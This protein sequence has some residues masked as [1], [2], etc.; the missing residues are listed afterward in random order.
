MIAPGE[1]RYRK[2]IAAKRRAAALC[3]DCGKDSG[4]KYRCAHCEGIHAAA[5]VRA[6]AKA[7]G[8]VEAM[9]QALLG[10]SR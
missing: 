7:L 10:V 9:R 6:R 2:K 8:S 4:A 3:A 5:Q 1:K